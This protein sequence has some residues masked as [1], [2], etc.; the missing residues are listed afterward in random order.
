M[1]ATNSYFMVIFS[2]I[3]D[4]NRFFG[5]GPYFYNQFGLFIKTWHAGFNS[6]KE[7]PS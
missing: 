4:Q 2:N 1:L 7:M 5:G 6:S 3:V